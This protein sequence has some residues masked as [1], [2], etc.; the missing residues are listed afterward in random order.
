MHRR[1]LM[2]VEECVERLCIAALACLY[3]ACF[4]GLRARRALR[5]HRCPHSRRSAVPSELGQLRSFSLRYR[6]P[7]SLKIGL[8]TCGGWVSGT[9]L[10]RDGPAKQPP[11]T[12]QAAIGTHLDQREY[13]G[14]EQPSA[15][16]LTDVLALALRTTGRHSRTP[17]SNCKNELSSSYAG[18]GTVCPIF[19][20]PFLGL[21]NPFGNHNRVAA[22][23]IHGRGVGARYIVPALRSPSVVIPSAVE[24]SASRSCSAGLSPGLWGSRRFVSG[25]PASWPCRAGLLRPAARFFSSGRSSDRFFPPRICSGD[26]TSPS[27]SS[28]IS[29]P[30]PACKPYSDLTYIHAASILIPNPTPWSSHENRSLH[31]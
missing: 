31:R 15:L 23:L 4:T 5:C 18:P 17:W 11:I 28:L 24:G 19:A 10:V 26:F 7:G 16:R 30:H 6:G 29:Y 25:S 9:V 13:Q 21:H 22:K 12:G 20:H 27:S 14:F 8:G 2:A 1:S 3:Q